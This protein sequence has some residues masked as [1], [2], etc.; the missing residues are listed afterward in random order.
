[1]VKTL[2]VNVCVGGIINMI[3]T[4]NLVL[5]GCIACPIHTH[6]TER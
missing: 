1:M 3:L 5:A 4:I 2:L 6:T